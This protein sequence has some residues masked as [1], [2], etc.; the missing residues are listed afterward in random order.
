MP[1]SCDCVVVQIQVQNSWNQQKA[2]HLIKFKD[3]YVLKVCFDAFYSIV[4]FYS[5]KPTSA[6]ICFN[7]LPQ[8]KICLTCRV[9]KYLHARVF[10]KRATTGSWHENAL[11]SPNLSY[12]KNAPWSNYSLL[13]SV[14]VNGISLAT[15]KPV[16]C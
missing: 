13:K 14:K 10:R 5:L 15:K 16:R 11:I 3:N 9:Y 8:K 4:Q 6:H 2:K 12:F 7:Y 1:E